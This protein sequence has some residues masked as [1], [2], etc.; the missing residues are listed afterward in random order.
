M[1]CI[2]RSCSTSKSRTVV[3]ALVD[4]PE[5]Q[6]LLAPA[7]QLGILDD[8][9]QAVVGD[10]E[11]ADGI[12]RAHRAVLGG[13]VLAIGP[14]RRAGERRAAEHEREHADESCELEDGVHG[15]SVSYP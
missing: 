5:A 13:V 9:P 14:D 11:P 6:R 3:P 7:R 15:A 10:R 12:G 1:R 4:D 2:R 8:D